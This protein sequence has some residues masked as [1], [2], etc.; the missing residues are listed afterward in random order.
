[1]VMLEEAYG[2]EMTEG[3]AAIYFEHLRI[4]SIPE[5]EGAVNRAIREREF[6]PTVATL[7]KFIEEDHKGRRERNAL[8]VIYDKLAIKRKTE[9][10]K[11]LGE[12][13]NREVIPTGM[14]S[15]AGF[16]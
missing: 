2:K 11:R 16:E 7:I 10:G 15:D 9:G 5:I 6:F 4:Y 3:R 13:R 8:K 12:A 14:G 1:M